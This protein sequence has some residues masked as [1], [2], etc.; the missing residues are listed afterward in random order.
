MFSTNPHDELHPILSEKGY[1]T[2]FVISRDR[3]GE[4]RV[5]KLRLRKNDPINH[6][7]QKLSDEKVLSVAMAKLPKQRL[8]E[9]ALSRTVAPESNKVRAL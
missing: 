6:A 7:K 2:Q 1:R 5:R 3:S 8:I 4:L 9:I